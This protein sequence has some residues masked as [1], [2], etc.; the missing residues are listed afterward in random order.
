[1]KYTVERNAF[2]QLKNNC[3]NSVKTEYIH[4]VK[5]VV[6]HYNTTIHENR[7]IV[8]GVL[9][10]ITCALLRDSGVKCKLSPLDE[11]SD[12][13]ILENDGRLAINGVFRG[14]STSVTVKNLYGKSGG[15][16]TSATLFVVANV[17]IVYGD[18]EMVD[19]SYFST[20]G[21]RT[22]LKKRALDLFISDPKNVLDM[23]IPKNPGKSPLHWSQKASTAIAKNIMK[24]L[25]LSKLQKSTPSAINK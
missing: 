16:W 6:E 1:M 15:I 3:S 20:G 5:S 11:P 22:V 14:G 7:F 18:P 12:D 13:L 24:E 8:G 4:A 2:E 23:N 10:I 19:K 9:E 21:D 25:G 17:G